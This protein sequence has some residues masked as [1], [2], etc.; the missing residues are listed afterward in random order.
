ME[1]SCQFIPPLL[2]KHMIRI[3]VWGV[4]VCLIKNVRLVNY[5]LAIASI[6]PLQLGGL[7]LAVEVSSQ[8]SNQGC[9]IPHLPQYHLYNY[10]PCRKQIS[11]LAGYHI[12]YGENIGGSHGGKITVLK[13]YLCIQDAGTSS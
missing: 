12:Y 7:L 4:I 9:N 5:L 10:R 13:D 2:A 1:V 8:S 6:F 3:S 11:T